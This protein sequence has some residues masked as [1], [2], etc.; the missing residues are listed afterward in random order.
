MRL[1]NHLAGVL[2]AAAVHAHLIHFC[3]TLYEHSAQDIERHWG[4]SADEAYSLGVRSVPRLILNLLSAHSCVEKFGPDVVAKVPGFYEY[5]G[6]WRLDLD[7]RLA[8]HGLL[9][10]TRNEV[11]WLTS[12]KVFRDARDQYP[13]QLR[14]RKEG[15]AA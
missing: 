6:C 11:G 15:I 2:P 4:I 3:L 13:F 9:F 8:R 14:V 5:N 7:A 1:P 12:I 10:P